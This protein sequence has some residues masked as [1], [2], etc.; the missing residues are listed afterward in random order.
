LEILS[1]QMHQ[2]FSEHAL[3]K[4]I[5]LFQIKSANPEKSN[6][7]IKNSHC[8][9]TPSSSKES[10]RLLP[11]VNYSN[12]PCEKSCQSTNFFSFDFFGIVALAVFPLADLDCFLW[13]WL[14]IW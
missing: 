11:R 7:A 4:F 1:L 9:I 14:I 6:F 10:S 3:T 5:K 12:S 2:V 8:Q 13:R